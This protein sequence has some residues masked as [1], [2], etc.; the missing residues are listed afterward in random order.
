MTTEHPNVE[1]SYAMALRAHRLMD[2]GT[3][4]D[5]NAGSDLI[6]SM[7]LEAVPILALM[8]RELVNAVA[9]LAERER[10]EVLDQMALGNIELAEGLADDDE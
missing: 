8:C 7:G 2:K 3:R 5:F 10:T 1:D 9:V 4:A 6:T